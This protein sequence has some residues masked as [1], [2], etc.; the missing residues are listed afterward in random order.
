VDIISRPVELAGNV[1]GQ[2]ADNLD[3]TLTGR[4]TRSGNAYTARNAEP[5][6]PVAAMHKRNVAS[7]W[8]L[9][10]YSANLRVQDFLNATARERSAGRISSGSPILNRQTI[11]PLKVE[12]TDVEMS[13]RYLLKDN[14]ISQLSEAN[15]KTLSDMKVKSDISDSFINADKYSPSQKTR[16]IQYVKQLN[17]VRNLGVFFTLAM[18]ANTLT[19]AIGFEIAA[20]NLADYHTGNHS[21]RQ[22]YVSD[23]SLQAI[24]NENHIINIVMGD[25]VYWSDDI[26]QKF[27]ILYRN[28]MNSGFDGW[29]VLTSATFTEEARNELKAREFTLYQSPLF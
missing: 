8:G 22:L 20:M 12:N 1:A 18:T 15:K 13:I 2:M 23:G 16:I 11:K 26:A 17:G 10:V 29:G 21:L 24:T 25:L 19:E 9:D 4:S 3:Q 6:D 27:E 7:Q 28:A 14:S 5:D